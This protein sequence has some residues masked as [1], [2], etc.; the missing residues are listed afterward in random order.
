MIRTLSTAGYGDRPQF[1][2]AASQ[3]LGDVYYHEKRRVI[4][5]CGC[6][7]T[8]LVGRDGGRPR[9]GTLRLCPAHAIPE[10]GD[11]ADD[12]PLPPIGEMQ[13]W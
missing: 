3:Y 10:D 7:W 9:D 1:R 8:G 2:G 4:A 5:R 6:E 11:R 12:R 13:A